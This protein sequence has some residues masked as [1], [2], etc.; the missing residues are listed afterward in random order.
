VAVQTQIVA[1]SDFSAGEVDPDLERDDENPV[2]KKGLRQCA[3]FRILNSK[4]VSNR[5]GRSVQFIDGPRIDEVLMAPGQVF[6]LCFRAGGLAVRNAAG[7]VVFSTTKKGDGTTAI[8]WT[9]AT[10]FAVSWD[11]MPGAA[12]SIYIAY[13]DGAPANVPQI[14][15][16]DG[17][18]QTSTWTLATFAEIVGGGSGGGGAGTG[19]TFNA[20]IGTASYGAG[21]T[22]GGAGNTKRTFF[23][24]ISPI[25]ITMQPSAVSG[26]GITLTFSAGMNLVAGHVGT[27]MRFIGRQLL[28]T[29]VASATSATATV[30]ETLLPGTAL[31]NDNSVDLNTVFSPGDVIIGSVSGARGVV[32]AVTAPRFVNVQMLTATSFVGGGNEHIVGPG[33]DGGLLTSQVLGTPFAVPVWDDE[34]MNSQ[35]RGYPSFVFCD[36]ARLGF[37][38]FPSV[39]TGIGYSA[40][41]APTD[42]FVP[43]LGVVP[44]NAIFEVAPG[45]S[46]VM[47]VVAGN[48]GS[49]FVFCDN[50][51]YAI[52]INAQNPLSGTTGVQF[53]K[54]TDDGCAAVQ[55][56]RM[57]NII[58]YVNAGGK[59]VRAIMTT[60]AYYRANESRDISEFHNHLINAPVA[61]A[62]PTADDPNFTERYFYVLNGD[63][64]LA[65]G[66]VQVVD[67][68]VAPN[69][70]P[71]WVPESGAGKV[72]WVSAR[73]SHVM[74]T[75]TYQPA[76]AAAVTAA[77]L[78][79][80][81]QYLDGAISYNS[82]PSG[83]ATP[84]GK[85]P[86]WWLAGGSCVVMDLGTRE[87][88]TYQI[89]ANGFLVPQFN[90]GEN[91]A[92]AQL[93][94]GQP[95][96]AT[97]EPFA[98]PAPGGQN[99]HQRQDTRGINKHSVYFRNSTGFVFQKLFAAKLTP[100]SPAYGVVVSSKRVPA[101]N[102]GDNALLAP[103]LRK[104]V[105][106]WQPGGKEHDPR[107]AIVKDTVGP[108]IILESNLEITV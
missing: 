31:E 52:P 37:C 104:D 78:R 29:A 77:E 28:I 3:N 70:L 23:Y 49:E 30:E 74:F 57:Q 35:L 84:G 90:G 14:L 103:P 102:A 73:A 7:T 53:Q 71:G 5:L 21:T 47:Y 75:T 11:I 83:I 39:R 72:L 13:A 87:L 101:Y 93:V 98:P 95:W 58:V 16:W 54:I 32:I 89:D 68:N 85:G 86:L 19:G 65:V 56:R 66:R 18:S 4:K 100:T 67:G 48:E 6:Y 88:G 108:L 41:N 92:S 8:P 107:S 64:T 17:V 33:G 45:K 15:T 10:A 25:G 36:Q 69:T 43:N 40:I 80:F 97:F 50:G 12:L 26:A 60:G 20:S 91:F 9:A 62:C 2:L 51:V 96:T 106:F 76:G 42:L 99:L 44:N 38:N 79:D 63:G 82:V 105:E 59:S 27:R 34:V 1:Q 22:S 61:I 24:R 46:Q 81:T 55:P 94:V